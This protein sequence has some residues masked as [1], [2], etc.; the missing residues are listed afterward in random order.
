MTEQEQRLIEL[1]IEQLELEIAE[2]KSEHTKPRASWQ[3]S[4]PL[5]VAVVG[6]IAT[7]MGAVASN[8]MQYYTTKEIEE[9]KIVQSKMAFDSAKEQAKLEFESGLILRALA[10]KEPDERLQLLQLLVHTE[11]I[12][13]RNGKIRSIQAEG[14]PRFMPMNARWYS[15]TL[16]DEDAWYR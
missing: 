5:W 9:N 2:R 10:P 14:L 15:R 4:I 6:A 8:Y 11:L 12:D 7:G 1:R 16:S 3:W 13:D